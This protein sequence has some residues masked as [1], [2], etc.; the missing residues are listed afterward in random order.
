MNG[1]IPTFPYLV[2]ISKTLLQNLPCFNKPLGI[3]SKPL[4][5]N[6]IAAIVSVIRQHKKLKLNNQTEM[7]TLLRNKPSNLT[8]SPIVQALITTQIRLLRFIRT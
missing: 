8:R 5:R 2:S 6:K 3:V 4:L 1:V 7:S